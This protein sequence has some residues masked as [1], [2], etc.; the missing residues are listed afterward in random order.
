VLL[1]SGATMSLPGDHETG[2]AQFIAETRRGR[3]AALLGSPRGRTKFIQALPH[4]NHW[5]PGAVVPLAAAEQTPPQ[6]LAAL[7]RLGAPAV[8]QVLSASPSLDTRT[9]PLEDAVREV[10]GSSTGTV[11]SCIP[12]KLAY[13]EGEERRVRLI[14]RVAR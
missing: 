1:G 7:G 14:L 5:D 8:V 3:V 12:G 2:L 10:V 6:V 9:L 11:I 13:F 4:F